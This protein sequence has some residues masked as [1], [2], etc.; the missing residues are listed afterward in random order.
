MLVVA[1]GFTVAIAAIVGGLAL[2]SS[3]NAATYTT[4]TNGPVNWTGGAAW[5][6]SAV[7]PGAPTC[8]A[9]SY[10]GGQGIAGDLA[11]LL[12]TPQLTVNTAIPAAVTLNT[13]SGT[14]ASVTVASGGS[15]GLTG[16]SA[17]TGTSGLNT[18]TI[19][20]GTLTNSGVLTVGAGSSGGHLDFV[21]GT[22]NG[23]GTTT[24][25]SNGV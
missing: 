6:C 5:A 10:P 17:V 20:S 13:N 23:A 24:I 1:L 11:N 25:A 19:Q 2:T 8:P 16:S 12:N 3:V 14:G 7:G 4:A 15:L 21:S 18:L 9:G 22:L